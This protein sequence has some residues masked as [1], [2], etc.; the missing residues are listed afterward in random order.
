MRT[1]VLSTRQDNISAHAGF[2]IIFRDRYIS[3]ALAVLST[4]INTYTYNCEKFFF[5]PVRSQVCLP[6]NSIYNVT[7]MSSYLDFISDETITQFMYQTKWITS[8]HYGIQLKAF[9]SSLAKL[10][11]RSF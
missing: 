8:R 5:Q 11:S 1:T 9:T 7:E 4:A 10:F 2:M 6:I 3:K